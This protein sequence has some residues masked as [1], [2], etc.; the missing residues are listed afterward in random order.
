MFAIVDI[1][2]TGGSAANS[3]ITEIAILQHDGEKITGQW[4]SL[5]NPQQFIPSHI[6]A[7]TGITNS[8][9][10]HAPVLSE[11]AAE[12]HRLLSDRIFVAHNVNFD[13]S[14]LHHAMQLNGYNL[15]PKKLCTVRYAR[16]VVPGLPRYGLGSLCRYFDISNNSRHRAMGD[17]LATAQ[18]FSILLGL[19]NGREALQKM[20][21]GKNADMYL[22][23]QLNRQQVEQ[24]P[25]LPGVY[26][27]K[28]GS[29]KILY[30]GKARNLQKRVKQHFSNNNING[31]KQEMLRMIAA[32]DYEVCAT[33][34]HAVILEELAIKKHWPAFNRSQKQPELLYAIYTLQDQQGLRR[35]VIHRRKLSMQPLVRVRNIGEGYRLGRQLAIKFDIDPNWF[36]ANANNNGYQNQLIEKHNAKMQLLEKESLTILPSFVLWQKGNTEGGENMFSL[37][38]VEAGEAKACGISYSLPN[39]YNDAVALLKLHKPNAY[40]TSILLSEAIANPQSLLVP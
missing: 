20:I 21:H 39:S 30:V 38:W 23:Q 14:F 34:M 4:S 29:G 13:Y 5:L 40:V 27:F 6:T 8:M 26:Y 7:L 24:L 25:I 19:D 9:V 35:A 3:G 31:R 36:F 18:L 10:A 37:F 1:E 11:V 16:K 17:A 32:I 33:E 2:T 22:P 15:S 28:N 12:I